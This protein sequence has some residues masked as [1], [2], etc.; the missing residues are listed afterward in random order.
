MALW[1]KEVLTELRKE[2]WADV[3]RFASLDFGSLFDLTLFEKPVWYRP[4]SP[5][6]V[7]L[8]PS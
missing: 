8:L 4:D 1:T 2:S 6:P 3:F 7:P 5:T